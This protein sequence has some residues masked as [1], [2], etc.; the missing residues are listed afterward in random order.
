M[1]GY[2]SAAWQQ[3]WVQQLDGAAEIRGRQQSVITARGDTAAVGAAEEFSEM[4]RMLDSSHC[5]GAE[6]NDLSGMFNGFTE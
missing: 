1:S 5:A 4:F 6:F 2:L 3:P